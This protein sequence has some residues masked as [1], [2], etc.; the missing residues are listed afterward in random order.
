MLYLEPIILR[1][2]YEWSML[3]PEIRIRGCYSLN[4]LQGILLNPKSGLPT[5]GIPIELKWDQ[6]QSGNKFNRRYDDCLV[7][8]NA[9]H[10]TDYFH[11]VF[12]TRVTGTM[13]TISIYRSGHSLLSAQKNKQQER[14]SSNSLFVNILGAATKVDDRGLA[15]EYDYY[16]LVTDIIK[17]TFGF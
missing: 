9:E 4:E 3:P 16:A 2:L 1:D 5:I 17:S 15:E 13:S 14:R 6:I 8:K 7:L 10:P 12:T 11:F